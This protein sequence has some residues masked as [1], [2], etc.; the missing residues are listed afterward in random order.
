MLGMQENA[1]EMDCL[2]NGYQHFFP[3]LTI[4]YL[5]FHYQKMIYELFY[6]GGSA[7][8]RST[9]QWAADYWH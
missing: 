8:E 5:R 6:L 4:R 2:Y 1:I 3:G 7:T 9:F